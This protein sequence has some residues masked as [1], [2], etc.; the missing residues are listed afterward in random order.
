MALGALQ[1]THL[2]VVC[3]MTQEH[4]SVDILFHMMVVLK[5]TI[6]WLLWATQIKRARHGCD[7]PAEYPWA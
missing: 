3:D 1:L 5:N 7:G 2:H 4:G 6:V